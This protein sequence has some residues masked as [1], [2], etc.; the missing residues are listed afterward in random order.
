ML[1]VG[2]ATGRDPW[3]LALRRGEAPGA[4]SSVPDSLQADLAVTAREPGTP[5]FSVRIYA[6]PMVAYRLDVIGFPAVIAASYLWK[7]GRWMWIRHDRK[8]VREGVGD[9]LEI[10]GTSL[11]LPDV[12]A[13]LGFLW[14]RPLPGLIGSDSLLARGPQGEVRWRHRGE[15]WSAKLDKTTGLCR[16]AGSP[17]LSIRYGN[18]R[19][20]GGRWIPTETEVF[21]EGESV[22]L[23]HVREW[24]ESPVWRKN[25]FTLTPPASYPRL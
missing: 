16:E 13:V 20:H 24:K 19:N 17:S 15:I 10:E 3:G 5:P 6:K 11:R 21:L 7:D 23:L 18:Y 4:L 14:G 9:P 25:P 8:Q 22:L 2:C 12:H 1:L